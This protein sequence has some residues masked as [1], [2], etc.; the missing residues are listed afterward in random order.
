MG[1][2]ELLEAILWAL[3]GP[4]HQPPRQDPRILGDINVGRPRLTD[5]VRN[6]DG[7]RRPLQPR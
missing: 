6:A 7:P 1:L 4:G 3:F 5:N 2:L